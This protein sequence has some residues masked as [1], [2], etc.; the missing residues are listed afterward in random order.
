MHKSGIC[1]N[2]GLLTKDPTTIQNSKKYNSLKFHFWFLHLIEFFDSLQKDY[3]Q[4]KSVL[5]NRKP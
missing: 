2:A 5:A 1:R 4:K 3:V